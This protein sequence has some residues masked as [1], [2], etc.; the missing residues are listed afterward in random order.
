[1]VTDTVLVRGDVETEPGVIL[2]TSLRM[3]A[4]SNLVAGRAG[5][6]AAEGSPGLV[7]KRATFFVDE[8]VVVDVLVEVILLRPVIVLEEGEEERE[9]AAGELVDEVSEGAGKGSG[10]AL[11]VVLTDEEEAEREEEDDVE[12]AAVVSFTLWGAVNTGLLETAG[13]VFCPVLPGTETPGAEEGG[14]M[15]PRWCVLGMFRREEKGSAAVLVH[16]PGRL[17][18]VVWEGRRKGSLGAVFRVEFEPT[19]P[20][21]KDI[22][23]TLS[24]L[25]LSPPANSSSKSMSLSNAEFRSSAFNSSAVFISDSDGGLVTRDSAQLVTEGGT[26]GVCA[27]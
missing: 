13:G 1:M 19:D 26:V 20:V 7:V 16:K 4:R 18:E 5:L 21:R 23:L 2:V 6:V 25:M 8:G 27:D 11:L 3:A 24:T 10:R 17:G 9:G 12:V 22:S 14:S 15:L